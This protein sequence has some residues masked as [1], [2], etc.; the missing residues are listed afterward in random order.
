MY[1]ESVQDYVSHDSESG[2]EGHALRLP[3]SPL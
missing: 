3:F 1:G 2:A